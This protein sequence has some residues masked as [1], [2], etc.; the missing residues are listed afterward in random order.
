[1][2]KKEEHSKKGHPY[3]HSHIEHFADGS[4]HVHHVHESGDSKKD[5]HSGVAD[6]DG[7]IDHIMDHTSMPNPG[8]AEAQ[9]GPVPAT[10]QAP[11]AAAPIA[12]APGGPAGSMGA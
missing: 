1:M 8:E 2:A 7:M 12:P 3:S 11:A 9:A 10:A 5:V 6:H 4:H